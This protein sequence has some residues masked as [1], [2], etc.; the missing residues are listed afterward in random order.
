[1]GPTVSS[2]HSCL[3]SVAQKLGA[4]IC[5]EE[6]EGLLVLTELGES[7][8][9]TPISTDLCAKSSLSHVLVQ[10]GGSIAGQGAANS[11]KVTGQPISWLCLDAE[12]LAGQLADVDVSGI[13]AESH[14]WCDEPLDQLQPVDPK[15][16]RVDG[17]ELIRSACDDRQTSGSVCAVRNLYGLVKPLQTL[18]LV[19]L[20]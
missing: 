16:T 7:G 15:Q 5:S 11:A 4:F 12:D 19:Q 14:D 17:N 6:A 3:P 10:E 1:M 9:V 13:G 20:H 2:G 18:G 8:N